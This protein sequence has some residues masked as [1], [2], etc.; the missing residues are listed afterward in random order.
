MSDEL[1]VMS[2]ESTTTTGGGLIMRPSKGQEE[3][4]R[5]L[6]SRDSLYSSL[7]TVPGSVISPVRAETAAVA[8]EAR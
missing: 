8:G 7:I 5:W 6:L 1:W 4:M 3:A 2:D